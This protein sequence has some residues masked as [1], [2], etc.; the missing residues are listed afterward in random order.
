VAF[1]VYFLL[2]GAG[3]D[4]ALGRD[5]RTPARTQG[6]GTPTP[7]T[8]SPITLLQQAGTKLPNGDS[9]VHT[10][11]KQKCRSITYIFDNKLEPGLVSTW[12]RIQGLINKN[13]KKNVQAAG[14][15]L[16]VERESSKH[17]IF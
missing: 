7:A 5:D 3:Y 6:S 1:I 10:V 2:T 9:T 8:H 4:W 13:C 15:T 12:I 11:L 17:A 16:A 14:K